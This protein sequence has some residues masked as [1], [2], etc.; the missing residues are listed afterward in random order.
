MKGLGIARVICLAETGRHRDILLRIGADQ[1]ILPE[2]DSGERLAETLA[3]PNMLER[4]LLDADHSLTE[5][6]V[7]GSLVAQPVSSLQRYDVTVLL[8]QR[9]GRLIPNPGAETRLEQDDTLFTVGLREKLLEV[10]SLP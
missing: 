7:P 8:I 10:S 3:A 6:K 5:L 9:Q 2:E 4:V 1:V